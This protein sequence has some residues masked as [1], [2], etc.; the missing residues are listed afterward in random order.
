MLATLQKDR[1]DTADDTEFAAVK[2][3]SAVP[4]APAAVPMPSAHRRAVITWLSVYPLITVVLTVLG[5]YVVTLPLPVETLILTAIIVPA[6]VYVVVPALGR[7]LPP[8]R[9]P[10]K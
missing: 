7:L 2:S 3:P 6:S 5:P 9:S 1:A 4:V 8:Q 10:R